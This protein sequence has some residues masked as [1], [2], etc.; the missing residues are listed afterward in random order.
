MALGNAAAAAIL[1]RRAE[2]AKT[3]AAAP[4]APK[5]TSSMAR[6][7]ANHA[8]IA[9]RAPAPPPVAPP[10]LK[11]VAPP[12]APLPAAAAAP[13]NIQEVAKRSGIP[14]EVFLARMQKAAEPVPGSA[15][16]K[17]LAEFDYA[18]SRATQAESSALQGQ[19]DALTRRAAQAGGGPA[20]AFLKLEQQAAD[21]SQKRLADTQLGITSQEGAALRQ[22]RESADARQFAR[23]ERLG[24]EA[25][26]SGENARNAVMQ[27]YG[28]ERGAQ[29]QERAQDIQ[30]RGQDMEAVIQGN[31]QALQKYGIE[32]D[33][34]A[35]LR[36]I[37]STEG[38]AA[39]ENALKLK[40]SAD[41]IAADD[42]LQRRDLASREGIAGRELAQQ[43]SQFGRTLSE[44]KFVN[45]ANIDANNKALGQKG[46][47][48]QLFGNFDIN[49]IK[50]GTGGAATTAGGALFGAYGTMA[51][52]GYEF[53]KGRGW[54]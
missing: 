40:L 28:V 20:G 9:P 41:A 19:R 47:M 44:E 54:Y 10:A 52:A 12:K 8:T 6:L 13:V 43:E 34:A 48:D 1:R 30:I 51:G 15:I 22:M 11:E 18:R 31:A 21:D 35:K 36:Q 16:P 39:A 46:P 5:P 50:A 17:S 29:I 23:E 53:G 2:A 14:A 24:S 45:R 27:L 4:A 3:P 26:S 25:F 7:A 33:M 32:S 38:L 49:K 42:T 37:A